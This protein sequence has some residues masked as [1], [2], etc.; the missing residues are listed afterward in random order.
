MPDPRIEAAV[1]N[2]APRFLAQGVDPNDFQ[3][4][5]APLERWEQWLDAWVANGD[6]HAALAGDAEAANRRL[7]A[8]RACGWSTFRGSARPPTARSRRCAAPTPCSTP[9]PSG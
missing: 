2:W 9:P 3:R 7:T 6:L 5:T 8:G 4:V 1:A